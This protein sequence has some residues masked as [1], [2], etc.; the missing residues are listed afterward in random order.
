VAGFRPLEQKYIEGYMG[1]HGEHLSGVGDS[2]Y[3]VFVSQSATTSAYW[4]VAFLK[5]S[6]ICMVNVGLNGREQAAV[7]QLAIDVA[8]AAAERV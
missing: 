4:E 7:K 6:V 3:T 2:A 5:S 8:R 1:L